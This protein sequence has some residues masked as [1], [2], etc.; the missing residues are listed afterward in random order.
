MCQFPIVRKQ[1]KAVF[2]SDNEY[3]Y[4]VP[5]GKCSQCLK[6]RRDN[7]TFRI[8]KEMEITSSPFFV[9]L[10]YNDDTV[11]RTDEGK[12]TLSKR[13]VQLWLKKLRKQYVKKSSKQI[14]Y[15]LV[16]EYGTETDRPHY[17]LILMNMDYPDL[18]L[19]TWDKGFV[20]IKKVEIGSIKYVVSYVVNGGKLKD[21]RQKEFSLMSKKLGANYLTDAMKKY[22]KEDLTQ[23]FVTLQG[24][25]KMAMPKYYKEKIFD[26][27]ER[28][29]L[30]Q[31]LQQRSDYIKQQTIKQLEK[32]G[33][34]NP[35]A[36]FEMRNYLRTFTKPTKKSVL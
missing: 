21:G 12:L 9:T 4:K 3:T 14:R 30:T 28:G 36:E 16:G 32:E 20:K 23:C 31:Y 11:P 29:E 22:H 5:C 35:E 7:W 34:K 8:L 6:Q 13:D 19:Q 17:H 18:I 10:T 25:Y 1:T 2:G 33:Y 26:E 24:G 15:Y 27:L